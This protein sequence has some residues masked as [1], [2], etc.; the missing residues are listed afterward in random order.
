[1]SYGSISLKYYVFLK[2]I[3]SA[4]HGFTVYILRNKSKK[5]TYAWV[6][7]NGRPL[8]IPPC[9]S[10][11]GEEGQDVLSSDIYTRK[12]IQPGDGVVIM[13]CVTEK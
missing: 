9:P 7:P 5:V 8:P 11:Y 2:K 10:N 1:M 6:E 4:K 3:R 12:D 13:E